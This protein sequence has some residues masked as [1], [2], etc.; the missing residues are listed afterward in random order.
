MVTGGQRSGKSVFAEQLALEMSTHP[1]YLATARVMDE[2]MRRR[3]E[4]HKNRRCKLWRNLEAPLEVESLTISP[5]ETVLIDCLTMWAMNWLFDKKENLDEAISELKQQIEVLV[6][7]G[8]SLIFVTNEIGLGGTSPNAL[9]R[10]FT[11]LQGMINQYVATLSD[12]V[13]MLVSGIPVKIK[14]KSC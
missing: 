8:A 12:E 4:I 5:H 11:D 9:Q 1:T 10:K 7:T 13:Y 14:S 6:A 2:E 3:V